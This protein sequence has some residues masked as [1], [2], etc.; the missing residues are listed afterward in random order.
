[1][2]QENVEMVK[3]L[4]YEPADRDWVRIARDDA[5]WASWIDTLADAGSAISASC[6]QLVQ[7][8]KGTVAPVPTA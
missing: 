1:V 3:A 6:W 5:L 8:R 4:F 2:S 7:V